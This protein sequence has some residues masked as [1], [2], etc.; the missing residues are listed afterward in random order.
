MERF[1]RPAMHQRLTVQRDGTAT[2][3]F[4]EKV[5]PEQVAD[6]ALADEFW[7]ESPKG[8]RAAFA[9]IIDSQVAT[10]EISVT[11]NREGLDDDDRKKLAAYRDLA[12]EKGIILGKFVRNGE[13]ATAPILR[14]NA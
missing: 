8:T 14:T 12:R 11:V 10:G 13:T 1:P 9:K 7:K 5:T 4:G 3:P 6:A 2:D